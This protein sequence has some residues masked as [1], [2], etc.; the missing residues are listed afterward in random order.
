MPTADV[1]VAD[2]E[3]FYRVRQLLGPPVTEAYARGE[4]YVWGWQDAHGTAVFDTDQA[5]AFSRAY[6]IYFAEFLAQHRSF[7]QPVARC[8]RAWI[9]HGDVAAEPSGCAA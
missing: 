9:V 1:G 2:A 5:T 7:V 6:A 8:W 4:G 3:E